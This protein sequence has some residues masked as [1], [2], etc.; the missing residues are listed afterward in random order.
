M[1]LAVFFLLMGI[2]SSEFVI[3]GVQHAAYIAV[4]MLVLSAV[5]L[6]RVWRERS[7]DERA[8]TSA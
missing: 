7:G 4:P 3:L 6:Y 1:A 8:P 5:S 2:L